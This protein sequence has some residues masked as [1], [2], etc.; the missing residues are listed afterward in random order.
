MTLWR[1]TDWISKLRHFLQ[2]LAFTLAVATIQYAFMPDRAYGPLVV[3]SVL[4][5]T[6]TWAIIDLGREWI[7]SAAETGWPAGW[8]GFALVFAGIAVGYL[9]G[10]ALADA[11]CTHY[12]RFTSSGAPSL[13]S[14]ILITAMA[15]IAGS[16]YF[17][18]THK[19]AYLEG[20]MAEA[21]LH[22]SEARL[23]LLET[24][25][26]PH[27]LFN[28]LANLRVLIALDPARAQA[29][30]DHLIAYLRAT[31]VAS[32]ATQHPLA[33][34]FDRL[35]D[36]LELMAVRM[37]PRLHYTLDLPD[38]LRQVPVPPLLLQPL[39][40]NAIR[41]GLEPQVAGGHITVR[42]S[43][44]PSPTS[45]PPSPATPYLVLEVADTGVGLGHGAHPTPGTTDPA[46]STHFG[47][48]QVRERL[49]TLHGSAGT[50][51]LIA[52]SAGGTS[53]SVR[54]PLKSQYP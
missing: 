32:R 46:A 43:M 27:M 18:S 45:S 17:Y 51:D 28:T 40:E 7:P 9:A 35:R 12:F 2:V 44:Q 53:A 11:L 47:L 4:I 30:L 1:A 54:F 52:A 48:A 3:Y 21:R 15:G 16:Y 41:H 23:K 33:D 50:L 5:G 37:G 13:R 14:S 24:Q 22:A 49:A 39:V 6:F 25:L 42:A 8:Q 10:S 34:E 29:M 26:E 31:L 36:Y 20:K 38:A 19:S